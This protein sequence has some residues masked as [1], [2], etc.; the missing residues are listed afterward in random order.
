MKI[1]SIIGTKFDIR[2][3]FTK[4]T[5]KGIESFKKIDGPT[6]GRTKRRA[7]DPY[8]DHKKVRS[9]KSLLSWI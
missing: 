6:D 9:I 3:T 4:P 1:I 2:S 7:G 8:T 5:F